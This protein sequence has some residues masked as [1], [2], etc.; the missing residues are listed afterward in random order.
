MR[1]GGLERRDN[2]KS[3]LAGHSPMPT[4]IAMSHGHCLSGSQHRTFQHSARNQ[5]GGLFRNG[6]VCAFYCIY[7]HC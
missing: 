7:T 5:L 6:P 2:D 1:R 3:G 4:E